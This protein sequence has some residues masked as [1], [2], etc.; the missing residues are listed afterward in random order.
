[1]SGF[2][3]RLNNYPPGVTGN[4]PEI[5]GEDL[6]M[7]DFD[8][9][10]NVP[11]PPE[12]EQVILGASDRLGEE[13]VISLVADSNLW[14]EQTHHGTTDFALAA[15]WYWRNVL[16]AH[17][18]VSVE[19]DPD[20]M[21]PDESGQRTIKEPALTVRTDCESL[22]MTGCSWGYGGEGPHATAAI[23]CDLGLFSSMDEARKFVGSQPMNSAWKKEVTRAQS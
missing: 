22:S 23:L 13:R 15:Y 7:A 10:R 6:D 20:Y 18:A 19:A 4:E 21:V 2:S 1:M 3:D 17:D 9:E 16:T 8:D 14:W 5:T 12:W 11:P